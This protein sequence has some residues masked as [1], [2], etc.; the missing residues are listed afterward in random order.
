MTVL[1]RKRKTEFRR[2]PNAHP[3]ERLAFMLADAD[4]PVL[5]TRTALARASAGA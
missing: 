1:R 3:L 4:A 5:L 2:R